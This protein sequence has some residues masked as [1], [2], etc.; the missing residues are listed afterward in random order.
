[1]PTCSR[2]GVLLEQA[3]SREVGQIC[4]GDGLWSCLHLSISYT[5]PHLFTQPTWGTTGSCWDTSGCSVATVSSPKAAPELR[6]EAVAAVAAVAGGCRRCCASAAD[7]ALVLQAWHWLSASATRCPHSFE[8]S[9]SLSTR[10]CQA[11]AV[12]PHNHR[13]GNE[14]ENEKAGYAHASPSSATRC[15]HAPARRLS[16]EAVKMQ[17]EVRSG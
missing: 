7:K 15:P 6:T 14:R 13:V 8:L 2:S 10:T 3:Q 9:H 5:I 12:K 11:A 17:Q 4:G 1:M 16:K